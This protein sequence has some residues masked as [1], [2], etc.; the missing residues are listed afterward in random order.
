MHRRVCIHV[1]LCSVIRTGTRPRR[2]SWQASAALP[3][4]RAPE[5]SVPQSVSSALISSHRRGACGQRR[6]G[7]QTLSSA[8]AAAVSAQLWSQTCAGRSFR[9]DPTEGV[10]LF[11]LLLY[12]LPRGRKGFCFWTQNDWSNNFTAKTLF[13]KL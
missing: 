7:S 6:P 10:I 2:H 4:C 11:T 13:L 1:C 3:R 8:A 12:M 5:T 9:L